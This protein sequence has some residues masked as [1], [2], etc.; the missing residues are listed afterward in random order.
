MRV[1]RNKSNI[2]NSNRKPQEKLKVVF[3]A[4]SATIGGAE[5]SL[6][7]LV[8]NLNRQVFETTVI[9]PIK[10]QLIDELAPAGISVAPMDIN[11]FSRKGRPLKY[12]LSLLKLIQLLKRLGPDIIHC[13]S[14]RA[15]HWGIPLGHLMSV[16]TICH[17]RD[18]RYTRFSSFLLKY[19]SRGTEFI[20]ISRCVKRAL[21]SMGIRDSQITLIYN[22]VDSTVYSCDIPRSD[23]EQE[24]S[25]SKD[26]LTIGV[27][28]RIV[29]WKRHIDVIEAVGRLAD[30]IDLRLFIVGELWHDPASDFWKQIL[31][32]IL[33]LGLNDKVIFT[34]LRKDIP[35]IMAGLDIIIVPSENEPFGRVTVEAMAMGKPVIGTRSGGT[36]EIIQHGINGI[37]V[38][39]RDPEA[40]AKAI[41]T[42]AVSKD[43]A[44]HLGWNARKH[45]AGAFSTESH[46]LKIEE[47]YLPERRCKGKYSRITFATQHSRNKSRTSVL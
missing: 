43:Y 39:V 21:A 37:L 12:F 27:I 34:G 40:L 5:H 11:Y 4:D 15:A 2:M 10:G 41:E 1:F 18:L 32:R 30:R 6:T 45:V 31:S 25:S 42:I 26:K 19:A 47:L 29:E 23:F 46:V 7:L 8:K 9:C 20:A 36:P 24:F 3:L 16:R 17:V 35:R 38:P 28:G 22:G 44:E 14:V 13:N 33:A